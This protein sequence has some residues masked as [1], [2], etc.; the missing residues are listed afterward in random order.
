MNNNYFLS[1]AAGLFFPVAAS[2]GT[3]GG[4]LVHVWQ[5]VGTVSAGPAW[6]SAE[7]VQSFYLTPEI[8]KSYV[9]NESTQTVDP[10]S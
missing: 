2:A 5:W 10:T 8:E 7:Q 6:T 3:M 4:A 1:L 9:A